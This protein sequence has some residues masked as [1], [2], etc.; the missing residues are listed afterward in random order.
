[1]NI[2]P[3][4]VACQEG[5]EDWEREAVLH[6]IR[7]VLETGRVLH[8]TEI[9][10]CGLWRSDAW[11]SSQGELSAW[12]SVDWYISH[13][14]AE[15]SRP[16][17]LNGHTLMRLLLAEPCRREKDGD[18]YDALVVADDMYDGGETNFVLG[19]GAPGLGT[20][21]SV[22]RLRSL[23]PELAS[24]CIST[25]ALHEF[26][27][28]CGLI[29]DDR[30]ENFETSLGRHCTN[31]CVMRQGLYVPQDWIRFTEERL[32]EGRNFCAQCRD[33]LGRW[34]RR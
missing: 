19:L 9:V 17:Q 25:L 10:D 6:A 1:M 32:E 30:R 21:L 16:T 5:V 28:A 4:S 8:S 18:H 33:E 15:S 31:R 3:V 13:A 7:L 29:A 12:E 20:V 23:E 2:K 14:R 22:N 24:L 27:H 26:G 11:L 34:F